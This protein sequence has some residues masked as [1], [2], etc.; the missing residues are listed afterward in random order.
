MAL[1]YLKKVNSWFRFYVG[2][3]GTQEE[4]ELINDLQF[5][6]NEWMFI[7]VNNALGFSPK[8]TDYAPE[9]GVV[10]YL[11]KIRK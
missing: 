6:L 4:W 10:F 8:A 9:I 3:E 2:V 5:H 11:N 1:E 7:R